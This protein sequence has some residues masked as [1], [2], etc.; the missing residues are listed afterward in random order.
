VRLDGVSVSQWPKAELGRHIGF[1]PQDIE[2]FD[3]TL[4]ENIARFTEPDTERL[5]EV[6]AICG[7][8]S[9][10]D[11][12]PNGLNT[13]L[14]DD[15]ARLSGGQRQRIALAR[16]LYGNPQLL[17]LDEPNANLDT[18]GDD[19]LSAAILS[20]KARGATQIL[21]THRREILALA[22]LILV[23]REGRPVVFGPKEKV[24]A[25]MA[26]RGAQPT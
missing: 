10:I 22:D 7:L 5:E 16:A 3:G 17:V 18:Q 15:G 6:V 20:A 1:L 8:G 11:E 12:L 23:L 13:Q 14:G 24:L 21:I 26:E 9:L 19:A 2:L 4:A 25:Q